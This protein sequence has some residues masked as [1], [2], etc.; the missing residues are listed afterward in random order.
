MVAGGQG[1]SGGGRATVGG[2]EFVRSF[3]PE[4]GGGGVKHGV[5][6]REANRGMGG[7]GECLVC[8]GRWGWGFEMG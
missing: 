6:D 1:S 5:G 2:R 8:F 3:R 4:E 7:E